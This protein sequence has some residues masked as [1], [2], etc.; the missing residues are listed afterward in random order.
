MRQKI[1][2]GNWKMHKTMKETTD[3]L[4]EFEKKINNKTFNCQFGIASS[5]TNLIAL[6]N[7]QVKNLIVAAQNCHDQLQGAF[8]GEVSINML[9]EL[10]VSHVIIGHSERRQYFNETN[11]SINRKL[12]TIFNNSKMIPILCCGE[13]LVQYER[14]TTDQVIETQIK[15]ALRDISGE[16][17]AKLIIAYEPIWA[18]GTGKTAS[19]AEAQNIC[20]LIRTIIAKLYQ[21]EIANKVRI[22]YGGSVKPENIKTFLAQPDIDGALVGS[23]SLQVTDFINLLH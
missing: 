15:L 21:K 20:A 2:I 13:T 22:Q 5:F 7:K 10:N 16:N 23:A 19:V 1:I 11:E 17:V 9:E 4:T 3:F 18:I 6:K 8:T 12:K 14:K